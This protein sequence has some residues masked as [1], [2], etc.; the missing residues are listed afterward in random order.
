[1]KSTGE[2]GAESAVD[3]AMTVLDQS[4]ELGALVIA[5]AA[6]EIDQW[7]AAMSLPASVQI[8]ALE[9]LAL[10]TFAAE[11]GAKKTL[12]IVIRAMRSIATGDR[13]SG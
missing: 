1:M 8:E 2:L 13:P 7:E 6:G 9:K 5:L 10:L 4:G 12:E 3:L 11:G